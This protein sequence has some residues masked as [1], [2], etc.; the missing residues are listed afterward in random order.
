[1][2]S[3]PEQHHHH[4]NPLSHL[5]ENI[6]SYD[7]NV[8]LA[9]VIS[10]LLVILFVLLLHI[11]AKWFLQQA[12]HRRR[13][14]S[15]RDPSMSMSMSNMLRPGRFHHFH[16][17]PFDNNNIN[18]HHNPTFV[19]TM[20]LEASTIASIPLFVYSS[21]NDDND[22]GNDGIQGL[23][24]VVCLSVFEDS[25]VC[26]CLPKCGHSFHVECI[27][28]WLHSHTNCPICRAPVV[29]E[30]NVAMEVNDDLDF[31]EEDS[32]EAGPELVEIVVVEQ[33]R[34]SNCEI[35][36]DHD[37][38]QDVGLLN[39]DRLPSSSSSSSSSSSLGSSLK[40]MLSRN[41]RSDHQSKVFPSSDNSNNANVELD[42][43]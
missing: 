30:K 9:A 22:D 31:D 19:S 39:H 42:D 27:D 17:F 15:R 10:L 36:D 14:R 4:Q 11:Y 2:L 8:M 3:P 43:D 28:M 5:L 23:E 25:D 26:R 18:N 13:R 33:G 1:M 7:G 41:S 6:S 21:K 24:C 32:V 29:P 38:I 37:Q 12:R 40:R 35:S 20:G 16:S 34:E